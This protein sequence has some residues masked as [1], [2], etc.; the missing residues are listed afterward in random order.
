[1]DL[2][3]PR[4]PGVCTAPLSYPVFLDD[5]SSPSRREKPH[6]CYGFRL[7]KGLMFSNVLIDVHVEKLLAKCSKGRLGVLCPT[8]DGLIAVPELDLILVSSTTLIVCSAKLTLELS[9][10]EASL[11]MSTV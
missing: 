3:G 6:G 7:L 8:K 5:I 9:L 2:P 1:M 11:K 4:Y 10:L